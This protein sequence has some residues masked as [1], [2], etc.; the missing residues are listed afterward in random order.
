MR[1]IALSLVIALIIGAVIVLSGQ[2]TSVGAVGAATDNSTLPNI[3]LDDQNVGEIKPSVEYERLGPT[4]QGGRTPPDIIPS[5]VGGYRQNNILITGQE[6]WYLHVDA[7]TA[8]WLY[9]YE[10]FPAAQ[11]FPGE[12]IAY[13]WQLPQSG[14]WELGPF[15][16]ASD[17]IEGQHIYRFWFYSDGVWVGEGSEN[18]QIMLI[19]WTYSK[20]QHTEQPVLS[21]TPQP[22]TV[23]AG[24]DTFLDRLRSFF[25]RPLTQVLSLLVLIGIILSGLYVY[26]R[27]VRKKTGDEELLPVEEGLENNLV[28]SPP[29]FGNA[30]ITM[31]NGVE[32]QLNGHNK[33]V[34]RADLARALGLDE[35]GRISRRHFE[36]KAEGEQFYIEDLN[37]ANGTK[38][39]GEDI[40][41]KG[42]VSLNSDDVIEPAGTINLKFCT[43][44]PLG[45][46]QSLT[47]SD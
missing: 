6:N 26:R 38:L 14:V 4:S 47:P 19:Y 41:G 13:K 9:I 33:I 11:K 32:L 12:W 5:F 2:T 44:S 1:S 28:T 18:S 24:N 27:Y 36:I 16:A 20:G 34:G 46:N 3:L 42:M 15:T 37:S 21:V 29:V 35:L 25:S 17:E 30:K 22:P 7:N 31:P 8:G 10:Y 23:P 40:S 45:A 39:N 43:S